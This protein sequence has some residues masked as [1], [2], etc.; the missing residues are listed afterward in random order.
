ML[1]KLKKSDLD[2]KSIKYVNEYANKGLRTLVFAMKEISM[3]KEYIAS[4][5]ES[6]LTLLG[7]TG[8]EDEL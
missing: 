1:K 7:V 6:D 2:S 3:Q 4:E 5:V 8:V